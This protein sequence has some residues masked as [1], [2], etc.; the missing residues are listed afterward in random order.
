MWYHFGIDPVTCNIVFIAWYWGFV[1]EF[2]V[3][4]LMFVYGLGLG[5]LKFNYKV[6]S[7]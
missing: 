3:K 7:W 6:V 5:N 4:N 1:I 2:V